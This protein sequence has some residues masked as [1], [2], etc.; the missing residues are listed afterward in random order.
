[1]FSILIKF[2]VF[3]TPITSC[4]LPGALAVI[5]YSLEFRPRSGLTKFQAWFE[6]QLL[7]T[8]GIYERIFEKL[9]KN[10]QKTAVYKNV[11]TRDVLYVRRV[12]DLMKTVKVNAYIMM[13]VF[14][15]ERLSFYLY[16]R[17]KIIKCITLRLPRGKD[18]PIY[19]AF[20]RAF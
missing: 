1:M 10:P 19:A 20:V 5:T 16:M 3:Y 17:P 18:I 9:I 2:I 12:V 14:I 4:L 15:L 11:C 8:D 6:S 13:H 7:D